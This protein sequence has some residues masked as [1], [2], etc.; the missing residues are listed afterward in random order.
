MAEPVTIDPNPPANP[1]LD[2]STLKEQG[3]AMAQALA[4]DIWTDYNEHDPGVTALEQLCYALTELSYRAEFPVRDLLTDKISNQI[5]SQQQALYLPEK[6]LPC[7]PVT[8]DDYRKLIIDR[9]AGV[10]NVW[11]TPDKT[12]PDVRGLYRIWVYVPNDEE[13]IC[14]DNNVAITVSRQVAEVYNRHRD[15]CEDVAEVRLLA[16]VLTRVKAQVAITGGVPPEFTLARLFFQL[17]LLLAPEVQRAPLRSALDAGATAETIFN[18]PLL[19]NGLI[20]NAQLRD[21]PTCIPIS[22]V[23]NSILK[24]DGVINVRN[25]AVTLFEPNGSGDS[26]YTG[27][28]NIPIPPDRFLALDTNAGGAH[29]RFSI[30][31]VCNGIPVPVNGARVGRELEKLWKSYRR[32]YNLAAE[33]AQYFAFPHGKYRDVRQYYSIQNQFPNLYGINEYGV[34]NNNTRAVQPAQAKQFKGYLL[35][36]DQVLANYFAQLAHVK[37]LYSIDRGLQHTYFY[38]YLDHSVPDVEPLLKKDGYDNYHNG[39]PRIIHN[40]DNFDERRNRFLDVLLA[41]YGQTL[42]RAGTSQSQESG[43]GRY[44][45]QLIEAKITWLQN[46]VPG[47]RDRGRAFDYLDRASRENICAMEIKIRIQLDMEVNERVPLSQL[48]SELGVEIVESDRDASLGRKLDSYSDYLEGQFSSMTGIADN[49]DEQAAA[50]SPAAEVSSDEIPLAAR[51]HPVSLLHGQRLSEEFLQAATD[52]TQFRIG[53][54]AD[55]QYAGQQKVA[56]VCKSPGDGG[57]HFIESYRD[58]RQA[59]SVAATLAPTTRKLHRNCRQIYLVEHILLRYALHDREQAESD[60]KSEPENFDYSFTVSA[61]VSVTSEQRR[62]LDYHRTVCDIIR[63][64]TP[65]HLMLQVYFISPHALCHFEGLYWAWRHALKTGDRAQRI[66]T[67]NRLKHFLQVH[68]YTGPRTDE[69]GQW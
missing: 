53:A 63:Q 1:G 5:N 59:Q 16:P 37:D 55:Q 44:A 32:T 68:R 28:D 62:S 17:G 60:E 46:L 15:V 67:S 4:G 33:Y 31:L 35:A 26:T 34:V 42:D 47:T 61:V 65:A 40:E 54:Y 8:I 36:F 64:N 10:G 39:L 23:T 18:G 7:N 24:V 14:D 25:V 50:A 27:N 9:V 6:M 20:D 38:Q 29:G 21:K 13:C 43:T 66:I 69:A 56:L 11:L 3:L 19:W 22:E 48:C 2:Y 12:Q 30:A 52:I 57:W 49:G 41:I 58:Y 51:D 45:R